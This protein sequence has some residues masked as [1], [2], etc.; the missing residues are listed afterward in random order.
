MVSYGGCRSA[1]V[2]LVRREKVRILKLP[3]MCWP[4]KTQNNG[5]KP[6][7]LSQVIG[8][9]IVHNQPRVDEGSPSGWPR[10]VWSV[11]SF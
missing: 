4:E 8:Q 10:L 3:T 9:E 6:G 1:V 7:T 11:S 5:E 2:W